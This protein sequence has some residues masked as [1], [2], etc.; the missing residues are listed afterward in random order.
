MTQKF[1]NATITS[2]LKI[3][4]SDKYVDVKDTVYGYAILCL[5]VSDILIV[6]SNNQMIKSIKNVLK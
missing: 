6:G 2:A 4:E 1:D 5:D 3:N